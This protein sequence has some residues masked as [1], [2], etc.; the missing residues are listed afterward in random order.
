MKIIEYFDALQ[1]DVQKSY[2]IANLARAKGLDPELSVEIPQANSLAEKVV[3]LIS[4]I[5]PQ[6]QGTGI[7]ERILAL[8]KQYGT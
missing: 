3:G 7:V 1:K 2:D 4:A 8:E 6:I 5:Y